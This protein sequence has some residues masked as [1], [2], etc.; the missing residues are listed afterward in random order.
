MKYRSQKIVTL[1]SIQFKFHRLPLEVGRK[2]E[3]QSHFYL[4]W[5]FPALLQNLIAHLG[6]LMMGLISAKTNPKTPKV[7]MNVRNKILKLK[8]ILKLMHKTLQLLGKLLKLMHLMDPIH[9][10]DPDDPLWKVRSFMD[11]FLG[12]CQAEFRCGEFVSLDEMMVRF[13]GKTKSSLTFSQQPKPTP[14]GFKLISVVCAKTAYLFNAVIDERIPG[15]SKEEYVMQLVEKFESRHRTIVL[16][17]GYSTLSLFDRLY[18]AGFYAVGT[19]KRYSNLP[20]PIKNA[21]PN[22]GKPRRRNRE[23]NDVVNKQDEFDGGL[24]KGQWIWLM[25]EEPPTQL[26]A[27]HD[28]GICLSISTRHHVQGG[29]VLRRVSGKKHRIIRDCPQMIVDYNAQMG[30][31]D[32][33][34]ALRAHLTTMRRCKKWWHALMYWI[35]DTCFINAQILFEHN[36]PVMKRHEFLHVLVSELIAEGNDPEQILPSS[37]RRIAPTSDGHWPMKVENRS[38]CVRCRKAGV[39]ST[40]FYRCRGCPKKPCL[41]PC[42][43]SCTDSCNTALMTEEAKIPEQRQNNCESKVNPFSKRGNNE[44]KWDQSGADGIH[45]KS[46]KLSIK[47]ESVHKG[48]LLYV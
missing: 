29:H 26:C 9:D 27:W 32:R 8:K 34:D 31:V 40:T 35:L 16:D 37:G 19:I 4:P 30:G 45:A 12:N 13:S 43:R 24:R 38:Y 6:I 48:K 15:L 3:F 14:D 41:H 44:R 5:M 22:V 33:A 7:Q 21:K 28:S 23:R 18:Y 20:D 25:K 47:L 2:S 42:W 17:R 11:Y 1:L 10:K 36:F 39:D 46:N